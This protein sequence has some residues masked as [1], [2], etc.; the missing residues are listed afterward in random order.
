M[1]N[2]V[3]YTPAPTIAEFIKHYRP[4]QLFADWIVGPVGSG[5]TVGN[6]FK[7]IVMARR[8][9]PMADGIRR[10]RAVIVRNTMP[11]LVDTTI[12]SFFQW[13]KDGEAGKWE[14]SKKN[15]TIRFGDVEIEILFRALDTEDDIARVLSLE[16]TFA[17]IDEFVQIPQKIVQALSA[18]CGRYPSPKDG[19]ATN[20][21]LWGSSNPDTE[22]NWWF[23]ALNNADQFG[24][25]EQDIQIRI[26]ERILAG[27]D[28]GSNWMYFKQPGGLE[29][30][31]ENLENL[32]GGRAYYENFLKDQTPAWIQQFVH[33]EWGYSI[34]GM[35]VIATFNPKL[36]IAPGPIAYRATMLLCGGY[37]PGMNSAM[38]FG[39][40][41]KFGRLYI[42]DELVVRDFGT[43][44]FISDRLHPLLKT[45]FPQAAFLVSPDPAAN[46]RAQ[47][48]ERT[49]VDEIKK[50]YK[51]KIPTMNN[52]LPGRITAIENYTT[53]LSEGVPALQIDP[54]CRHL[55]RAL[56]AGW[57]YT[58]PLKGDTKEAPL[59]ND[60]SHV[61]DAFSY[62]CQ[63]FFHDDERTAR[64]NKLGKLPTFN[65]P[66]AR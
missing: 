5:K 7:L 23:D 27:R 38:V 14:A 15:F 43:K 55:I 35:P 65:N 3:N 64:R 28:P 40:C 33:A 1:T 41:D 13:F 61:G 34:A 39:Q 51:V 30:N 24:D 62:L 16:V 25:S 52:Q 44:R 4:H 37:D 29:P 32:P 45:R 59:K 36:H 6:F 9:Q 26:N 54:R 50:H 18:R 53:R 20:W 48:D 12:A 2:V 10:V 49:V 57:R 66:Y 31:A 58:I 19:G 46:Q 22:D 17:I 42:L 21:G 47:K 63:Y 60:A 56:R 11:Q 8:Q